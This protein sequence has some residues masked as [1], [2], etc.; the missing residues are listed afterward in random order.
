MNAQKIVNV[1]EELPD[2]AWRK[3]LLSDSKGHFCALGWLAYKGGII[4]GTEERA[5]LNGPEREKLKEVYGTFDAGFFVY[6]NDSSD[7]QDEAVRRVKEY[8]YSQ[9]HE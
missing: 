9:T 4:D 3:S 5:F 7:S 1:L 6:L 2:D 8:V